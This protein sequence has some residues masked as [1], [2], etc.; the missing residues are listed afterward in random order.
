MFTRRENNMRHCLHVPRAFA[1]LCVGL[2]SLTTAGAVPKFQ[3]VMI[4][5]FENQNFH[6][7]MK[8]PFFA[9]LASGGAQFDRFHAEAHPSEP[10][11]IALT[12]GG[13]QG[14]DDNSDYNL[15]TRNIVDLLEAK[16]HSWKVYVENWPGPCFKGSRKGLY[17]RKHNPFISYTDISGD[18]RRC[19]HIVDASQLQTDV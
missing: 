5:I 4:V 19:A 1:F 11:Y 17:A 18:A 9:K 15:E 13:T 12:S 16:G 6:K 8:Q 14:V 3:R 2:A 7:T 10:N